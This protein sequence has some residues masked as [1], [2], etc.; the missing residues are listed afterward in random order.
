MITVNEAV[1]KFIEK[2]NL[3]KSGVK[4]T[5]D[6]GFSDLNKKTAN[7]I[8]KNTINTLAAH[9]GTGKTAMSLLLCSNFLALNENL[10]ILFFTLE[11]PSESV[12]ARLIS[13]IEKK[14]VVELNT[15][16]DLEIDENT[17]E[18]IKKLDITFVENSGN[19]TSLQAKIKQFAEA[20]STSHCLV[21]I[22]HSLLIDGDGENQKITDLSNA[23]N[24]CKKS[25]KNSTYLII[26][27]L[28]DAMFDS[29][30]LT[31]QRNVYPIYTDL[32]YGRTLFQISDLVMVMVKPSD[33]FDGDKSILY[34]PLNLKQS[35]EVKDTNVKYDI[36]YLFIIKGRDSGKGRIVAFGDNL[37]HNNLI[38]INLENCKKK[39]I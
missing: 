4:M 27:Q 10:K 9:S 36:I 24:Y 22:D 30:R 25:F 3:I 15:E 19:I 17:Y 21:I 28:N 1:N 6:T 39:K 26:S 33:L 16:V 12:I 34:G 20:Y 11:M 31:K 29:N 18:K 35:D 32:Y 2:R 23:L 13:R 14:T 7:G 37:K 5:L 8:F 38:P